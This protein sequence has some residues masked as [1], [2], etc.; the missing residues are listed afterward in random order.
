VLPNEY[1]RALFPYLASTPIGKARGAL[2]TYYAMIAAAAPEDPPGGGLCADTVNSDGSV[3][4]NYWDFSDAEQVRRK[5]V[6]YVADP[7][8]G[9]QIIANRNDSEGGVPQECVKGR[10]Q[11]E[12]PDAEREFGK[13]G[14]QIIRVIGNIAA[15]VL[16]LVPGGAV[17]SSVF[18]VMWNFAMAE[19]ANGGKPPSVDDVMSLVVGLG[20]AV[21]PGAW[22]IVSTD[23]DIQ[24]I[25]RRGFIGEMAKIPGDYA[26]K[27]GGVVNNMGNALPAIELPKLLGSFDVGQWTTGQLKSLK[28]P[29]VQDLAQKFGGLPVQG[30]TVDLQTFNDARRY[31][32]EPAG[33]AFLEQDPDRREQIR[34]NFL[35][36]DV[37]NSSAISMGNPQ[38]VQA[39]AEVEIDDGLTNAAAFFDQYL[40]TYLNS[41]LLPPINSS[42]PASEAE[43]QLM[44]SRLSDQA[45]QNALTAFVAGLM[46]RYRMA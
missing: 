6:T 17:A 20:K 40:A 7:N 30:G 26:D 36:L 28:A 31:A 14:M 37:Q 23:P 1:D 16:S 33:K 15:V 13:Q 46:D 29:T 8:T 18:A 34:R 9:A 4:V 19:I 21:G 45:A 41:A 39:H 27:I 10:W 25:L 3:S 24:S 2:G 44:Q 11:K 38:G 43:R 42:T 35:W 22:K 12:G 32:F 5:R